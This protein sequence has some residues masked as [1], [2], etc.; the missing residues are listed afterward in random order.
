MVGVL[1]PMITIMVAIAAVRIALTMVAAV[2]GGCGNYPKPAS[3][4]QYG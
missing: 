1:R 2:V 3:D 4:K